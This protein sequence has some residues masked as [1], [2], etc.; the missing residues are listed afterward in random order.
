MKFFVIYKCNGCASVYV[1]VWFV[2]Y[3][4]YT[5][6][7]FLTVCNL[8]DIKSKNDMLSYIFVNYKNHFDIFFY[9]LKHACLCILVNQSSLTKNYFLK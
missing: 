6:R 2:I 1:F 5:N 9:K 8:L 3:N 7:Q 4:I